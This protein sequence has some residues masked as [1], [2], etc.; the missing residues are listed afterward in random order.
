MLDLL[1]LLKTISQFS[2]IKS[3]CLGNA[4]LHTSVLL[5]FDVISYSSD[6]ARVY[7]CA[8]RECVIVVISMVQGAGLYDQMAL[9]EC[10]T[11][12]C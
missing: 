1:S 7:F 12:S 10:L 11:G 4:G 8:K 6:V 9:L 3:K 5:L 2:I